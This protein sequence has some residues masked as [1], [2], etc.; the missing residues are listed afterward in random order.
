MDEGEVCSERQLRFC[1][2]MSL[3]AGVLL[4]KNVLAAHGMHTNAFR[5]LRLDLCALTFIGPKQTGIGVCC[6]SNHIY[7]CEKTKLRS[8]GRSGVDSF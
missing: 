1:V 7:H 6:K 8:K 3:G 5:A 4:T 2:P